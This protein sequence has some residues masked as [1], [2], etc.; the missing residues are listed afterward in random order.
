[1]QLVHKHTAYKKMHVSH[2]VP[3]MKLESVLYTY[4]SKQICG[5][6]LCE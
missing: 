3:Q 5:P 4:I 1:M 6:F 2:S